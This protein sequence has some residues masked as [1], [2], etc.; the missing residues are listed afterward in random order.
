MGIRCHKL[1]AGLVL[2]FAAPVVFA[3]SGFIVGSNIRSGANIAEIS[4][5]LACAVEY[6]DHLPTGRTDRLRIQIESTTICNG[7]SPT[8]ANSREQHRPLDADKAKLLEIS[9]DGDTSAGQSLT[10]T[11]TE[12][13]SL[14]VIHQGTTNDMVVRVYLNQ[15]AEKRPQ[16]DR[17]PTVRVPQKPQPQS[18]YVI[19]LSSSRTQHATSEMQAITTVPGLK[20][21]ESEVV[22]AGI[23]WYRL[24]LGYFKSS[25]DAQVQLTKLRDQYPTAWID[26]ANETAAEI[27]GQLSNDMSI[28]GSAENNDAFASIGLDEID[29]LMADAR[30]AIVTGEV[31]RAVQLYTKVLRAPNHDRHAE[32]QE[33]LALAREKNGQSAHAKAEYQRYLSLYPDGEGA[34][35]VS[36]RLAAL[37]ASDRKIAEPAKSDAQ[38]VASRQG[39]RQSDWR[40]QTFFSQYYRRDVNQPNAEEDIVSQSSLYSD[41]N[42]DARRRGK[43]FDFSSRLSAG[44]RNDFLGEDQGS[45]NSLRISYAYADLADPETGLTGRIGR[46]SRNTGGVLGRFDG[47]NLGYQAAERIRLD[48]VIGV[49]VNSSSDGIDSERVFY[50]LSADYAPPIE[51]LE[52]GA[53]YI[54]QQIEGLDDRQAIGGEFRYFGEK[55]NLWGLVDYDTLYKELGS[56]FLQGSW[57]VSSRLSVHGS[58]NRR[59]SPYLSTRNAM[60]GQPVASFSEMLVLWS[61]EEIH[62][63]SLDRSPKSSSYTLGLSQ[64]FS[65]KLQINFD[66]NQTTIDATPASGGIEATLESSFRYFSTT[67]VA[68]SLFTEGDVTMITLRASDSDTTKVLSMNLDTRFQLGE[69]WRINPRLRIDRRE[70]MSDSSDEWIYTPGIRAQLRP[71]RKYRFE[72]EAGKRFSQRQSGVIDLD[73]ESYFINFGYQAFF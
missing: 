32:A 60:I 53:F 50:G 55:Q 35:R 24:R 69:R 4:I 61:E 31:S 1:V 57:R 68:S 39:S 47:L 27:D 28:A 34:A 6:V 51:N 26:R 14:E 42:L 48:T 23:A 33:Y 59:Y 36:Q 40:V 20:V 2:L 56:A 7:V 10:L 11:F 67:L 62:Q 52:L 63:L 73:R 64:S 44:Y 37:L 21:F 41:V 13:V 9:Y 18:L 46:Q 17:A 8:I 29:Q 54:A 15:V 49:P 58:M 70:I 19:N 38:K 22:L 12:E 3:A 72:F 65:P 5:Q 71:S 16:Q 66:A 25:V 30:R 45:G 43:R